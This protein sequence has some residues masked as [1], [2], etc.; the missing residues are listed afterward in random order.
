[1]PV[2]PIRE[3]VP[4][5]PRAHIL[6]L[7]LRGQSFPYLAGQA[8][9][10]QP[11]GADKRRPYS[12]ASA[13]EETARTGLIEFLVQT[14]SDGSSGLTPELIRPGTA[15]TLEGPVGSFTF[16]PHPRERRF[17]FIAGGTGIAPL[18][19]MLW[20][21]LLA[22]RDGHVSL[23]YSVRSPEEFAYMREF[24][25]LADEGRIDFRHTVTRTAA[26]GWLGRQGRIDAACLDGLIEAGATLCFVCGPPALIGEIRPQ[27][28]ELGVRDDQI[29]I[30]NWSG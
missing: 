8:A 13:P 5:T 25:R 6:R 1:M 20:H 15:V 14:V 18:R 29:R 23:I 7:D 17:V 21:T 12:I 3:A 9:Y 26:E 16:P 4:A 19:S 28:M 10:L 11:E 2:F 30:E 24:Q 22:E 27:L